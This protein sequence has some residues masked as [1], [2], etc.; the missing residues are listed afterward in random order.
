MD[1]QGNVGDKKNR[2]MLLSGNR[3]DEQKS[4]HYPIYSPESLK[5]I[6]SQRQGKQ[7]SWDLKKN[8]STET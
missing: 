7:D 3:R 4:N 2:L 8:I 5:K 1:K 6:I